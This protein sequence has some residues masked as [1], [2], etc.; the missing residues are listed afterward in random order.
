MEIL[1][2]QEICNRN[3]VRMW[4]AMYKLLT[5]PGRMD[6]SPENEEDWLKQ[7]W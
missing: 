5:I 2:F 7:H 3:E 6:C 4:L 1:L